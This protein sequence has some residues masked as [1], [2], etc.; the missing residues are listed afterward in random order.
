[1]KSSQHMNSLMG[2]SLG[3]TKAERKKNKDQRQQSDDA[4]QQLLEQFQKTMAKK[5]KSK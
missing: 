1:M 5:H 2:S 4:R 3:R